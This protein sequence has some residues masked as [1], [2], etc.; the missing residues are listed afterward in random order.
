MITALT[1]LIYSIEWEK[2]N[3]KKEMNGLLAFLILFSLT[4]SVLTDIAI[5]QL[6]INLKN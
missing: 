2:F 6:L 4:I 5:F 3:E 1:T